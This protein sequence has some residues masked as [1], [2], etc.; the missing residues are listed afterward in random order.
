[1]SLPVLFGANTNM[2]FSTHD[3]INHPASLHVTSKKANELMAHIYSHL[4]NLPITGLRFLLYTDCE[5]GRICLYLCLPV[6]L[7]KGSR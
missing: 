2:L 4:Y 3:N 5:V 7:L 6:I 1:M